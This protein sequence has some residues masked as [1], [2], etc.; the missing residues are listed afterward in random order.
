MNFTFKIFI[1]LIIVI[2]VIN[3]YPVDKSSDVDNSNHQLQRD[4]RQNYGSYGYY[5][6][7][8]PRRKY[9]YTPIIKYRETRK[10][11]KRLFVPNFFG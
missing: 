2:T 9:Q 10:K 6:V 1:F 3:C 11:K 5:P 7:E 8:A 4:K